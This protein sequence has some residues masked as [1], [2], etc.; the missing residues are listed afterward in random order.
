MINVNKGPLLK[1]IDFGCSTKIEETQPLASPNQL[2]QT[3]GTLG[4]IS[5]E[6]TGRYVIY[7]YFHLISQ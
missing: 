5:P 1:I 3:Y 4:Y 7:I 2:K 6:Q